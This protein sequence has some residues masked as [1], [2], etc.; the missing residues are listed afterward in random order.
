VSRHSRRT[1]HRSR[2]SDDGYSIVEAAITLPVIIVMTMLVVQYALLWHGR[3]VAE[4]AARDGMEAARGFDASPEAGQTAA[5]SF[6]TDVA[7][8]LLTRPDVIVTRT[9]TTVRVLVTA[10]VLRVVPFGAF[11][12]SESA[13]GP[14][15]QFVALS[16]H[17]AGA[18]PAAF[19]G[20]ACC[21]VTWR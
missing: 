17:R 7:P 11:T 16:A 12:V 21:G 18:P 19:A 15:E 14:I 1:P 6:L 5:R 8:N 3:H 2:P 9:P 13:Q 20:R 4:S 10:H